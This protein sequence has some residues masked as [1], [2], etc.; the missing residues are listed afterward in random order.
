MLRCLPLLILLSSCGSTHFM[1]LNTPLDAKREYEIYRMES[2]CCG[3]YAF[4]V[5]FLEESSLKGQFV[6]GINCMKIPTKHQ[7]TS[8]AKGHLEIASSF[9]AV[10]DGSHEFGLNAMEKEAFQVL[11]SVYRNDRRFRPENSFSFSEITGFRVANQSET[12][13]AVFE[14]QRLSKKVN[15]RAN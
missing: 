8:D 1:L 14:N 11:D 12:H 3:C 6:M 9:I 15:S 2:G 10:T 4:Y 13:F 7:F 5:N